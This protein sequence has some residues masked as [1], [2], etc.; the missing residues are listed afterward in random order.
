[1]SAYSLVSRVRSELTFW[2]IVFFIIIALG[3]YST[4][5]RF[6]HGLGAATNLSDDFPWGL[7]I[8]FDVLCGVGLAAG[9]FTI[10]AVVYIF[11]I[12]RFKTIVRPAILTAFLGYLIVIIAIL[13]DLGR[14][15][16]IWHPIIMWNPHSV[17]FEVGWCVMLYTTVLALEF[18]PV[19]FE[20]LRWSKPLKI[21]KNFLIPLVI[22]GVLF[23]TLHQ[24][25]LGSLYLVVP[26][27]LYP[28]WYSPLLPVLFFISAIAVG[29]AMVIF[30]S[31]LSSRAF[32]K[33]LERPILS[34]LARIVVFV[35]TLYLVLK[36]MDFARRDMWHY[37]FIN[38][39]ETYFFW[40]EMLLGIIVPMIMLAT[41][42]V[43]RNQ[44]ALFSGVLLVII[45]FVMNRLN[46]AITGMES[47][48]AADYFPSWMEISVTMMVVALGFAAFRMA[49]KH[50]PIFER[51]KPAAIPFTK[52]V[53]VKFMTE[54]DKTEKILN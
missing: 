49:V 54:S 51:E 7:W 13:F 52:P 36:L 9:G 29:F 32:G 27:K 22:L 34:E 8:G 12:K 46:V 53:K 47:Y 33:N 40:A 16:R 30:E 37:M 18:S 31:Y 26:E 15:Y 4:Y 50:L 28:L 17:M 45:G 24:S 3:L 48:A 39:T 5:V 25:S 41:P 42:A 1:M 44:K 11:N 35:L 38:R 2:K 23:S 19:V 14:P 21:I 6:F 10:A 20:K 43:R